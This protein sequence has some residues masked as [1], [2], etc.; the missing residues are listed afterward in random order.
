MLVDKGCLNQ[1]KKILFS[2]FF[3]VGWGGGEEE[4]LC[5]IVCRCADSIYSHYISIN[6][7]VMSGM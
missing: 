1:K 4:F 3:V 5:Q 2:T 6:F 7:L